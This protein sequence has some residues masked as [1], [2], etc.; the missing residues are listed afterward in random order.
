MPSFK[1]DA[2][3]LTSYYKFEVERFG[4]QVMRY[5]QFTNSV[6]NKLGKEPLP[7]GDVK[8]FRFVSDRDFMA[9]LTRTV[10][11]HRTRRRP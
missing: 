5:Y 4:N 1:T 3:P 8:A 10:V 6:A 11:R 9:T 7:N 2:V